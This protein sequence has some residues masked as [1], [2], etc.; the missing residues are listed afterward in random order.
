[1]ATI[2]RVEITEFSFEVSNI[3]LEQA[4]AGVGNMAYVKGSTFAARRFALRI[5][6]DDGASGEY[7]THWVGTPSSLAQATM[8][9]PLLLGRN[10][11]HREQI[12]DD[13]KREL[14]A[15]DH[16][17]HGPLDIALWDLAG[18]RH[19]ASVT[20][21]LGGFRLRLPTYASTYHGQTAGGG[22]DSPEAFADFAFACR[23]IPLHSATV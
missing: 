20:A 1:M 16:M 21:L 14:R 17:G 15:Y 18:K 12:Y 19:G 2:K 9:A 8:L 13:L 7:V 22:L 6:S 4:A 5:H 3:G 23:A 11:D 10:P